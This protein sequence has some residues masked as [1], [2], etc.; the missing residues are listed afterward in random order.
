MAAAAASADS[1][2]IVGEMFDRGRA[3]HPEVALDRR[4][5]EQHVLAHAAGGELEKRN[6]PDLFLACACA[7]GE[8]AALAT[9]DAALLGPLVARLRARILPRD[10]LEQEL[11]QRLL[12]GSDGRPPRIAEYAGRGSL[13]SWVRVAALRL[14]LNLNRDQREANPAD[15]PTESVAAIDPELALLKARY[16]AALQQ[17]LHTAFAALEPQER[18]ILRQRFVDGL[19]IDHLAPLHGFHRATAARRL[20]TARARLLSETVRELKLSHAI[21]SNELKSL[22]RLVR[23]ELSLSLRSLM[24]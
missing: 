7:Q 9:F 24:A 23:S 21:P 17:A 8:A 2:T 20:A 12:I 5:F 14:V 6:G 18:V 16:R 19:S 22:L 3:A 1:Q 13:A 15:D 11:R 10:D 4:A